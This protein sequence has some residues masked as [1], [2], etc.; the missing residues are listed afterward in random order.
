[1]DAPFVE[2]G[3]VSVTG[4]QVYYQKVGSYNNTPLIVLHGGPGT[5][6]N[7]LESLSALTDERQVI[8]YDQ[9]G[10]GKSDRPEKEELWTIERF[11]EELHQVRQALRIDRFHLLGHSWGTMLATDYFLSHPDGI[12][13]LILASPFLNIPLFTSKFLPLLIAAMPEEFQTTVKNH[14]AGSLDMT[15]E[16]L[17]VI[18]EYNRRYL[19]HKISL[20]SVRHYLKGVNDQVR[21]S[22]FGVDDL[23]PAGRI[24]H[25]DRTDALSRIQVPVLLTCGRYD[26]CTPEF[27]EWHHQ[28]IPGS[29]MMVFEQSAHNPHLEEPNEFV[30]GVRWFLSQVETD[31]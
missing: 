25:Y 12:A 18:R 13:S 11:V 17:S 28:Q 5:P 29:R 21:E 31:R 22:L 30:E 4:G 8:Y 6:H 9:L 26:D 20:D 10:C 1:M 16:F 15:P 23:F 27:L 2:E 14:V 7:Y 24:G 3:Y 19:F